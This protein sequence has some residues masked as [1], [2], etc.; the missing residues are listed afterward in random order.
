MLDLREFVNA[1]D[2]LYFLVRRDVQV[3]YKQTVLG[4]AWAVLNPL[5]TVVVFTLIFGYLS[6]IPSDGLPYA[7]FSAAAVVPWVYFATALTTAS[8]SLVVGAATTAPVGAY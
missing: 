7:V 3:L 5:I 8:N 4:I 6:S 2:S 1:R